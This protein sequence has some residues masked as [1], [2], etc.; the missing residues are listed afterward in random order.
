MLHGSSRLALLAI[1]IATM[2]VA[3]TAATKPSAATKPAA[4]SSPAATTAP[5]GAD[6]TQPDPRLWML[7]NP[8][9]T[10]PAVEKSALGRI[11]KRAFI[12][13]ENH[14]PEALIEIDGSGTVVV[15]KG[16]TVSIASRP[17]QSVTIHVIRVAPDE[18]EIE[19][20]ATGEKAT[21]H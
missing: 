13:T 12:Q 5:S 17:G 15:K 11:I 3:Q 9:T 20:P 4:A 18:I 6:P 19:V 7:L 2:A 14:E 1:F 8:S 16:S 10:R 21:I